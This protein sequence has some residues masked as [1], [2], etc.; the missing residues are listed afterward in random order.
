[1]LCR[2]VNAFL[3]LMAVLTPGLAGSQAVTPDGGSRTVT[4][5]TSGN[6]AS[7]DIYNAANST[8]EFALSCQGTGSITD[9]SVDSPVVVGS[10][11]FGTAHVT[12]NVGAAGSGNLIL[13]AEGVEG[14]DDGWYVVTVQNPPPPLVV[15]FAAHNAENWSP[16]GCVAGCFDARVGYTTPAYVSFNQPRSVTLMHSQAQAAPR[17]LVQVD[18]TDT[19]STPGTKMSIRL[20]RAD[21]SWVT[22]T[23]G[24]PEIFFT[25]GAGPNR[26]SAQFDAA[27]MVTGAHLY[28][29]HVRSWS[30]AVM[31]REAAL[32]IHVFVLNEKDSEFGWGW[33]VVGLQRLHEQT[34]GAIVV[35][36]GDGTIRRFALNSCS[37]T[38]SYTS[39]AGDFSTLTRRASWADGNK[40]DR[41]YL[42]GTVAVY[43]TDGRLSSMRD[44]F[45]NQTTFAYSGTP[46]RLVSITDPA[47][48]VITFGYGADNKL[49]WIKDPGNRY[50]YVSVNAAKD[51]TEITDPANVAA[52]KF[53]YDA[54]HRVARRTDRRGSFWGFAYDFSGKLRADTL[55]AVTLGGAN[56]RPVILLRSV[57]SIVLVDPASGLGT[58]ANPASRIDTSVVRAEVTNAR[59]FVTRYAVDRWGAATRVEEPLGRVSRAWR[60]SIGQDTLTISPRGDSVRMVWTGS[61]LTQIVH[62]PLGRT[63]NMEYEMSFHE[64]KRV[65]GDVTS[66][67]NYWSSGRLDSVRIGQSGDTVTRFKYDSRGRDTLRIDPR[68]HKTRRYYSASSWQNLDSVKVES[69]R[70][71]FIYDAFGRDSVVKDPGNNL[72]ATHYDVLNRVIRRIGPAPIHDT[73]TFSYDS[74]FLRAVVDAKGQR[75]AF[76]SNA[77]GW[78]VS[79]TNP[80][81]VARTFTYDANGNALSATNRRGQT[82]TLTYDT[83]DNIRTRA[84]PD[85]GTTT[86]VTDPLGRFIASANSEST[87]TLK[88]DVSGRPV[89]E[90]AVR[91]GA[92]YELT[93]TFNVRHRRTQLQMNG[94]SGWS[95][96]VAFRYNARS[97]LD[98]LIDVSGGRTTFGYDPD[99]LPTTIQLPNGVSITQGFPS[100]HRPSRSEYSGAIVDAAAGRRYGYDALGRVSERLNSAGDVGREFSYD[101]LGRI[102]QYRDF[103]L[104]GPTCT[105]IYEYDDPPPGAEP[106]GWDCT[107]GRV[108]DTTVT[109]TYDE[110]GN[111]TDLGS[112]IAPGNRLVKF[113]G[114]SLVYDADGNLIK[115]RR[116][117][118]DVQRLHWNSLGQLVAVWTSGVDSVSFAYDAS[119]RRAR[120]W[121]A[122]QI[123]QYLYDGD[124]LFAELD[125]SG[126][127]IAEYAYYWRVDNPHSVRR[128]GVMYYYASE[129]P[130]HITGLLSSTGSVINRYSYS[131]F[132]VIQDSSVTI[133]SDILR[134]AGRELDRETGLY[135]MRARYYDPGMARFISEDPIGLDGGINV[136]VFAGNDPVNA[137]D[138][139]GLGP[140]C[141]VDQAPP[142][143]FID[144][145]TGE[146]GA[147]LAGM[148]VCET[149]GGGFSLARFWND[150]WVANIPWGSTHLVSIGNS[151]ARGRNAPWG[152][153]TAVQAAVKQR[154][155]QMACTLENAV[156]GGLATASVGFVKGAKRGFASGVRAAS[157]RAAVALAFASGITIGSASGGMS[158]GVAYVGTRALTYA[159]AVAATTVAGAA[160][161]TAGGFISGAVSGVVFSLALGGCPSGLQ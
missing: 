115:R 132:G 124:E 66:L 2:P 125:G 83:L 34:D 86:F 142:G 65:Y 18:V 50:T 152:S 15:S 153:L 143:S 129:V 140:G 139:S 52:F 13:F 102:S 105:P 144:P 96:S 99:G 10:E 7:F 17:G 39:P 136:Y 147:R 122:S 30:G 123:R 56:V 23:T 44:R 33:S 80:T 26:L 101:Q 92:R 103:H 20:R 64:L 126:A 58:S 141:E 148:V 131:P 119:G 38:C 22:F 27:A 133:S 160:V 49:D 53:T 46:A 81:G 19:A 57:E 5:N 41:V 156:E 43:R 37:S 154:F 25:S 4:A 1:M 149:P 54:Q 8:E 67:W 74:L 161:G 69:R 88:V 128:S 158:A 138:P 48:K 68:D 51:L 113:N 114:D 24:T 106:I 127:V 151:P 111:R 42:D 82:I 32:P 112:V 146:E 47:N 85:A 76:A 157:S 62:R 150:L 93:S 117:G 110:V 21:S 145:E 70:T 84:T 35:T 36:E 79:D 98:T 137:R 100:T 40:W 72:T 118:G 61:D 159:G 6:I 28:R 95:P 135:L 130:G 78:I 121:S 12:F 134:Y 107:Q 9:C 91:G 155:E 59:G 11:Q 77:L 104:D 14:S 3:L 71:A 16:S 108:V 120:K 31:L 87:D 55:P 73:T 89:A 75:H 29:L 45:N 97:A 94:P 116:G 90:I 60:N 109:Y 63:I